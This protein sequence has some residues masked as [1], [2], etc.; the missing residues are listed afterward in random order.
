ML[1]MWT[2]E[3]WR[4]FSASRLG[5]AIKD[6]ACAER[7]VVRVAG[8]EGTITVI[9]DPRAGPPT[10]QPPPKPDC[11]D[12]ASDPRVWAVATLGDTI[13]TVNLPHCFSCFGRGGMAGPYDTD[14]GI[15]TVLRALTL[16]PRP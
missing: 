6:A 7:R 5:R 16:R 3:A 15:E 11:A 4:R 13:V 9:P 10:D 1:A 12:A 8:G 2:P 14:V